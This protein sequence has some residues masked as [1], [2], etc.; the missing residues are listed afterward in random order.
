LSIG[1]Q[2]FELIAQTLRDK[3]AAN[4]ML[5]TGSTMLPVYALLR[6]AGLDLDFSLVKTFNLDEYYPGNQFR[7]FMD[8]QLFSHVNIDEANV[9]FPTVDYDEVIAATGGIDLCLLG[10]GVNGHIAFNEPGSSVDSRTRVVELDES[11]R[12]RNS[13]LNNGADIPQRAISVGIATILDC[14]R[15]VVLANGADKTSAVHEARY[16]DI[17]DK[18]P[19]SFLQTH[20]DVTWLVS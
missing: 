10:I 13:K 19:A 3:P 8:A 9:H 16:S 14:K 15:I 2:A 7:E 12:V 11:T 18:C 17:S 20:A 4:L 1:Q 6:E 5:A